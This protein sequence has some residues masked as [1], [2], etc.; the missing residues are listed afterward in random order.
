MPWQFSKS[1]NHS[2]QFFG[3]DK[4]GNDDNDGND[5]NDDNDDNSF[6]HDNDIDDDDRGCSTQ[7]VDAGISWMVSQTTFWKGLL[8]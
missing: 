5:H 6:N 3:I 8:F 4:D 7:I 1:E 2:E